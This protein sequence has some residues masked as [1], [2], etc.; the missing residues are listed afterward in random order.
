MRYVISDIHGC[1]D[2][3]MELLKKINLKDSDELYVIGDVVDRGP[4]PMKVLQDMMMRVNVFPIIG[5]HD[6]VALIMLKKLSVEIT[7]ENVESH[8]SDQDIEEYMQWLKEGAST[9]VEG[10]RALDEDERT[11]IIEYLEEFSTCH[12]LTVDGKRFILVHGGMNNFEEEK[13]LEDYSLYDLVFSRMDYSKRYFAD[14]NT[15]IITGHTPTPFI[16]EDKKPLVYEENGHIAID[17]GCVFGGKL[18][19]YCLDTG[20][21]YYVEGRK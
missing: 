12:E 17:C 5:N 3:Y 1:Y 16:R 18:A 6:V 20:E 9:T 10:F 21:V 11:D 7:E 2:E 15:Y 13:D 19:A 4:E 14:E 8:L